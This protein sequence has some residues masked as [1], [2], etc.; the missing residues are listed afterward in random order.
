M[1]ASVTEI[2]FELTSEA[3]WAYEFQLAAFTFPNWNHVCRQI[4]HIYWAITIR[5]QFMDHIKL[6]GSVM[7]N[8][9]NCER[10]PL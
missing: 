9:L 1:H 5:E 4:L 6:T 3:W 2:I 8:F 10:D 7:N